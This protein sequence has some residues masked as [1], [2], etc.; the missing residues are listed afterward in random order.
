LSLQTVA[1]RYATALADVAISRSEERQVQSELQG[2]AAMLESN[3]QLK[4]VFSNPTVPLDQKR[5]VLHELISRTRISETTGAF[6]QV[7]LLNQRL[8]QLKDIVER[9]ALILDERAGVVAAHV[10]TARPVPEAQQGAL[11]DALSQV[12]GNSVRLSFATDESLIGG[13]VAR[14]G[15]TIFDGSVE[16]QLQRLAAEM[17]SQ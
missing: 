14:I 1:R 2:W 3:P 13:L 5:R 12:T 6:L 7:L 8:A 9:L 17:T 4:E 15:S 11:R 16:S 10:T